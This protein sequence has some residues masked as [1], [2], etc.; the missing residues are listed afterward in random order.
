VVYYV[1]GGS[2]TRSRNW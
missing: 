1:W 2:K